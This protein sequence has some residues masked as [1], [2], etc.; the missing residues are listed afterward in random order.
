MSCILTFDL[1]TTYFKACVFN[2][3]GEL[4][5]CA[6]L[7][8][9]ID[10]P[11]PGFAQIDP[12]HFHQAIHQLAC[13]LQTLC[14]D[15]WQR[16]KYI[17]FAT[18]ANSFLLMDALDQPLTPIIVWTD[19]RA[20]NLVRDVEPAIITPDFY[21]QTGV[22][23]F[24]E[25]FLPAK[26]HWLGQHEPKVW[27]TAKRICQI[28]DYL[29]LW[30]TGEHVTE[31]GMAALSGLVDIH[32]LTWR[33]KCIAQL[34]FDRLHWPA[35]TRAG[36]NI[37]ALRPDAAEAL[38]LPRDC[39]LILGCL[40]QYAGAI[41][42]GNVQPGGVS[43]TTGTVLATV[44]LADKFDATPSTTVFQGPAFHPGWYFRMVFGSVAANLLE[45]YR[46]RHAPDV[47]YTQLDEQA[48]AVPA[49]CDGLLLDHEA[50]VRANEPIFLNEKPSHTHGHRVR[51]ILEAVALTLVEQ[52][53][54]LHSE[55]APAV[56]RSVGGAAASDLWMNI[57]AK[58]LGATMLTI[59]CPEP[60]CLGAAVLAAAPMH[61]VSI[62][63]LAEQWV[64]IDRVY[65]PQEVYL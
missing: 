10:Q 12:S 17:S 46:R 65:K 6:R 3:A 41:G 27:Q 43:E 4:R 29:T 25:H 49:D 30:L 60:T 64:R 59:A 35:V 9:P 32:R 21:Q 34:G 54:Q 28:S 61:Q 19:R 5:G 62:A 23:R 38:N 47:S 33:E 8:T 11:Q 16:I 13:Q 48:A 22:A 39:Q 26:L 7:P 15:D 52:V 36:R 50:S 56:I 14:P 40:D 44:G 37:G 55:A 53:E 51:A 58:R 42:A 63:E 57:K 20:Q 24:S 1:G 2:D 45:A 31:A 18:Q